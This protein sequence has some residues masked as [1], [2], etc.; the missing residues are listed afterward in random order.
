MADHAEDTR[1]FK[2]FGS[3]PMELQ[4][5]IWKFAIPAPRIIK[6]YAGLIEGPETTNTE[7]TRDNTHVDT[8]GILSQYA[9][10]L[11]LSALLE[12]CKISRDE[13]LKTYKSSI[14]M[15]LEGKQTLYFDTDTD[16]ILLVVC[17]FEVF[18]NHG[19][20]SDGRFA[21]IKTLA[22]PCFQAESELLDLFPSRFPSVQTL[23][24]IGFTDYEP[25]FTFKSKASNNEPLRW[26][27]I[28]AAFGAHGETL[29][30]CNIKANHPEWIVPEIK[31]L[32]NTGEGAIYIDEDAW[33]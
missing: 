15:D 18:G 29:D 3:L 21:G 19:L 33:W 17:D 14:K 8:S 24:L 4:L 26:E 31:M 28:E 2:Q 13:L 32:Y 22:L 12:T 16:I 10:P 27:G 7:A 1:A 25:D 9:S 23:I 30:S 5:R 6:V 20:G 11:Q